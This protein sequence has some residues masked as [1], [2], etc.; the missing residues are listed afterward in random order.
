MSIS[1]ARLLVPTPLRALAR[2]ALLV[3]PTFVIVGSGRSGTR[4]IAR[5]LT[6]GGIRTGHEGW[7]TPTGRR[8][9]RLHGDASWCAAFELNA[10]AGRVFHQIREPLATMRSL[11]A[12]DVSPHQR[13]SPWYA[14]R[15][16]HVTFTGDPVVDALSTADRW[17]VQ[18]ERVAEWTWRLEDVDADLVAEIGRR[19]GRRVNR[20][21]VEAALSSA[22]R[23]RKLDR[24]REVYT[25]GWDDLPDGHA[26]DRVRRIA[27][28][29]RYE[30]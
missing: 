25:F 1:L 18:S 2:R 21:R 7:W 12:L 5:V 24:I 26:K 15:T 4:F 13:D 27:E 29:Y 3:E 17:L 30:C 20:G 19:L 10:Y 6:A 11:A 22:D 16:R 14:S 23:N 8:Q 9:V 28:R